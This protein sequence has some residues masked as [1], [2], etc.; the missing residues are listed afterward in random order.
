MGHFARSSPKQL[1]LMKYLLGSVMLK[2]ALV[3]DTIVLT[4]ARLTCASSTGFGEE[5]A[6]DVVDGLGGGLA[7]GGAHDLADKKLED[8][9]LAGLGF[10][11][12]VGVLCDN[13]AGA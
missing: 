13:F 5:L 6:E 4:S 8:A 12:V 9:F 10:G 11:D 1:A 2:A 3:N 7:A